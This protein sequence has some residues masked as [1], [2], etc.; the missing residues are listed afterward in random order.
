MQEAAF[1][2]LEVFYQ[3]IVP[4]LE[5]DSCALIC[6]STPQGKCYGFF[7]QFVRVYQLTWHG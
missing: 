5:M 7:L 1:M 3:V 6:I 4:L 2:D